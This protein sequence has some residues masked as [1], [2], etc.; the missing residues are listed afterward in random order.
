MT[1]M[2]TLRRT[3]FAFLLAFLAV[4]VAGCAT[5]RQVIDQADDAHRQLAPAVVEDAQMRDYLQAM[6]ARI[7]AT[8]RQMSDSGY[9]PKS[10]FEEKSDWMF[11]D[12]MRFHFVNSKTLNAF[13]TGGDHM[14]IYT[15]LLQ[16]CRTEDELAAVMAHEYGHVYA[17]HVHKGMNRQYGSMAVAGLA[18]I[19]GYLAGGK[20]HGLE[21]GVG[22]AALAMYGMNFV[23][24][25]RTRE[26]EAEA[27]E[28]G[29]DFYVRSGWDPARFGDFFQQLID[30]GFDTTP[31]SLS[32]HP[33][34][35]SR[36]A[37]AKERA[38]KLPPE[39]KTWRKPNVSDAPRFAGMKQRAEMVAKNMPSDES[40]ETAQTLLSAVPSCVSPVD[41]PD[42]KAAQEKIKKAVA[43]QEKA[44]GGGE[45]TPK[46]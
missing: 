39:A 27:D 5:D 21:Y 12:Q 18:G 1:S 45:G 26:D 20:K 28:L 22:A 16:T 10:H 24:M 17:R 25:G 14:Y 43:E 13:T 44:D 6:G 40:L 30:K 29:F 37:A 42:Q 46:P 19:G 41:M 9:G 32:D 23:N 11:S 15:E 38:A 33:S 36:V 2:R 3:S 7:V 35:A 31:E 34:L 8:A 4:F